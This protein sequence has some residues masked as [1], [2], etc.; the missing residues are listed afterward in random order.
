[1]TAD[2]KERTAPDRL[3]AAEGFI[4]LTAR[5]LE[6]RRFEH[7]FRAGSPDAVATALDA[8][9][10]ADGGYAYALDPD[11]RG[12][13]SQ[14][15]GAH[16]ALTTLDEIGRCSGAAADGIVD[17]LATITLPDGGIPAVDPAGRDYPHPPFMPIDEDPPGALLTTALVAGVLHKNSSTHPWLAPATE[18]CWQ[19]IDALTESHPYEVHAAVAFLDHVPDRERAAAAAARLGRMVRAQGIVVLDPQRPEDS[20]LVPGYAPGEWHFVPDYVRDPGS[21]AREWFSE[22]EITA[23]LDAL[24]QDQC[25]DGGW[26]IRWRQW[27][28]GTALESRPRVTIDALR[29]LQAYGR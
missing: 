9:R 13:V 20:H 17:Q 21:L 10:S 27:A 15:L 14:P 23:G 4:W 28:P 29:T 19:R 26:P 5:V 1:M 24:A 6:Q 18:F 11:V 25:E 22:A 3:A 16:A 12:P 2:A 7:L 8:Y